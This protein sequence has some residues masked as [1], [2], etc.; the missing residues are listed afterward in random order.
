MTNFQRFLMQ[1]IIRLSLAAYWIVRACTGSPTFS[2]IHFDNAFVE[3]R[4]LVE[5]AD[6][7]SGCPS[8]IHR[9]NA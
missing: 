4:N 8:N 2:S 7:Y 6:K 9:H 5:E 1:A 3:L